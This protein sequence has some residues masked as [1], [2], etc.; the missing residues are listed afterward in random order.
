MFVDNWSKFFQA[1]CPSCH[2]SNS[3]E[4]LKGTQTTKANYKKLP[5]GPHPFLIHRLSGKGADWLIEIR[6][7]ITLDTKQDISEMFFLANLLA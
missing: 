6:F 4:V 2:P 5:S 1:K 7:Y 3:V